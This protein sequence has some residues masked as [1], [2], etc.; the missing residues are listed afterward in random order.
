MRI[1][2]LAYEDK[3]QPGS[4]GGSVRT[5]E[6]GRRLAV[7][8]DVTVVTAGWPGCEDRVEDGVRYVHA[9]HGRTRARS[10]GYFARIPTLLRRYEADLI[11]EDFGA[12]IS[13]IGVPRL[14]RTPVV[15]MVQWMFAAE[16]AAKYRLP[17][18]LVERWGLR[19]HRRLI[20]VSE[21]LAAEIRRRRPDADVRV[22]ANGV[23]ASAFAVASD[24][25]RF[26]EPTTPLVFLGRLDTAQKGLDVL[27]DAM[28]S[29]PGRRL[30]IAGDGPDEAR[31]RQAANRLGIADRVGWLG[32]LS[33]P[34][35]FS[36]LAGAALVVVPSRFETFGIVAIE[37]AAS[38]T[39]VIGS[40][41]ECLRDV[42]PAAVGTRVPPGD[43]S[44][45]ST[46]VNDALARPDLLAALSVSARAF[47][48]RFDW[49]ALA[50]Q[51]ESLFVSIASADDLT[52]STP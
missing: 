21:D 2:H 29:I 38:G 49:D 3:N 45:L 31:L 42:I 39:P 16:M 51:Q 44:A 27:L 14:T 35:K 17:F 32:R 47:A 28:P 37:A 36:L 40:D 8:H 20:A 50:D 41:I 11:V 34:D 1:L 52:R 33:G 9:G 15:G 12:P 10:A 25:A 46:A 4:G 48:R 43:P 6:I 19:Q 26:P 18:H 23:D 22:V 24:P 7:R 30:L 13:T 5:H